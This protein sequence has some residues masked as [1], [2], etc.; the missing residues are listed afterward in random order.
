M[1]LKYPIFY[2]LLL[3]FP[4]IALSNENSDDNLRD[5]L[6]AITTSGLEH[7]YEGTFVY[8]CNAQIIAMKIVHSA[9]GRREQEKITS[10]N[11]PTHQIVQEGRSLTSSFKGSTKLVLQGQP[12]AD[13]LLGRAPNLDEILN[14]H[15]QVSAKGKDRVAGRETR[16]LHIVPNDQYRYGY[17]LWLDKQTGLVLRS[18]MVD[19]AG[20]IIEQ[21]MFTDISLIDYEQAQAQIKASNDGVAEEV[22][23]SEGDLS[24]SAKWLTEAQPAGFVLTEHYIKPASEVQVQYEHM[25]L[26]DGL[27][28]VSVF[29]EKVSPNSESLVGQKKMGAVNAFGRVVS[30]YQVTVVGDV[31]AVTVELIAQ[32][33][34]SEL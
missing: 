1:V 28:S 25:V 18:D 21:V 14:A 32:S 3:F 29:I 13:S 6:N 12:S 24:A 23:S 16:I 33:V 2:I 27:A 15:Y 8:R 5:W 19:R 9:D 30:D 11:G 10:L 22:K 4:A 34:R 7:S 17:D 20:H 26:S 31:P